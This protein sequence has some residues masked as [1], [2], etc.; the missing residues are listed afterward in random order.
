MRPP[1]S[2]ASDAILSTRFRWR[3]R[4]VI[5]R[6]WLQTM[7]RTNDVSEE[8]APIQCVPQFASRGMAALRFRGRN[9]RR[10]TVRPSAQRSLQSIQDTQ[11]NAR[12]LAR[13]PAQP[14]RRPDI[15]PKA[16]GKL[17]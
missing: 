9:A 14:A 17:H 5:L 15:L 16:P 6:S 11:S 4:S 10:D 1:E 13:D 8:F 12:R 7:G 2:E 3:A